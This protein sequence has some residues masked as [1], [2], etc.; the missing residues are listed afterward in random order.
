MIFA[1]ALVVMSYVLKD[2]GDRMGLTQY[3]IDSVKPVVSKS[4]LPFIIFVSISL[5]FF[6]HRLIL[7][8]IRCSYS[9]CD[10]IG[11]IAWIKSISEHWSSSKCR[12]IRRQCL[13]IFRCNYSDW[14]KH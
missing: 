14:S 10:S 11:T 9:Y 1:L 3:V 12:R 6:Y 13:L 4:L 8:S 7:G 2:V 5:N